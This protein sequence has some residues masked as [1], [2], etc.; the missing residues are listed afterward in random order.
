V[1]TRAGLDPYYDLVATVTSTSTPQEEWKGVVSIAPPDVL[2]L[3]GS[4]RGDAFTRWRRVKSRPRFF[5][6]FARGALA[7]VRGGRPGR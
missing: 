6:Y 5:R 2:R 3:A 7:G 1:F 4:I